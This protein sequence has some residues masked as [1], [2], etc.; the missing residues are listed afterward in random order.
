MHIPRIMLIR[1]Q[2]AT[3]FDSI[4]VSAE[5][6]TTLTSTINEQFMSAP[7]N[8]RTKGALSMTSPQTS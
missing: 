3:D 1:E 2:L 5:L 8:K 4:P 7:G 6:R